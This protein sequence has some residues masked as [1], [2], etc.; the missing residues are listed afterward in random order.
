MLIMASSGLSIDHALW[1]RPTLKNGKYLK[2]AKSDYTSE[3]SIYSY[4]LLG[5]LSSNHC[6][7][8]KV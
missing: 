6:A 1:S 5:L 8:E 4:F 3:Q 2:F 7:G